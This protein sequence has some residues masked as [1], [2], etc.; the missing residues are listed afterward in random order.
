MGKYIK[1]YDNFDKSKFKMQWNE[2]CYIHFSIFELVLKHL[3]NNWYEILWYDWI[4]IDD[5]WTLWPLS[6]IFD[7]SRWNN[8]FDEKNNLSLLN[9]SK[10]YEIAKNEWY[11]LNNL[12]IDVV[13]Q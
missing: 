5:K 12:Y 9:I 11:N 13:Y 3:I 6:L 4:I 1:Y 2:W 8:T 7:F 10:L